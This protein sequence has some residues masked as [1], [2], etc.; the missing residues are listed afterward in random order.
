MLVAMRLL[1]YISRLTLPGTCPEHSHGMMLL[2]RIYLLG[3]CQRHRIGQSR[4]R[5][6][7]TFLLFHSILF[8]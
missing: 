4:Q 8:W 5:L 1:A 2:V 6:K 7:R 3:P